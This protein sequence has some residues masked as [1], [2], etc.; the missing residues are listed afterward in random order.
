MK[1]PTMPS[2][3]IQMDLD[4]PSMKVDHTTFGPTTCLASFSEQSRT[5]FPSKPG[6]ISIILSPADKFIHLDEKAIFAETIK[7]RTSCKWIFS[8]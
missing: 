2:V 4:E 3:T 1:L 8:S 6:R 7:V 5:T